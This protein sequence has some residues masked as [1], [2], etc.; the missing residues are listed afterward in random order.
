MAVSTADRAKIAGLSF[1]L[2]CVSLFLA[3]YSH[4]NPGVARSGSELVSQLV[5]PA[6]SLMHGV[7]RG[8][9]STWDEYLALRGVRQLNEQ[10]AGRLAL[11]EAENSRLLE[12]ESENQRLRGILNLSEETGLKGIVA[13]VIG[14]EPSNW[15]KGITIN[16]GEAEGV[17]AGQAVL[18]GNGVVGQVIAVARHTARVLLI[19]DHASNVDAIIQS[20]RTRGIV[21][22]AGDES[23]ELRYVLRE[24][25]LKIG[26]RVI[27]SGM[28][29]VYPKGLFIGI[30]AS[31]DERP[32]GMFRPVTVRPSVDF[33]R[34]ETVLIVTSPGVEAAAQK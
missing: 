2:F 19:I 6:Q 8:L 18:E 10:L 31:M 12:L 32:A 30:V 28:D 24:D 4:K 27:T 15:V 21:A 14:Y 3:A 25:E 13:D 22:G 26:D 11:L 16:K 7:Y 9:V 1:L 29:S 5:G 33:L 20:S 17:R 23:C 34:L